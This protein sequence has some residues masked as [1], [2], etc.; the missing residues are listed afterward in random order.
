MQISIIVNIYI[1]NIIIV[2]NFNISSL[3]TKKIMEMEEHKKPKPKL[4][5][6]Q[7]AKSPSPLK[8][9]NSLPNLKR[10]DPSK[11]HILKSAFKRT[12]SLHKE[13]KEEVKVYT[14]SKRAKMKKRLSIKK[15]PLN[16]TGEM[17]YWLRDSLEYLNLFRETGNIKPPKTVTMKETY[18]NKTLFIDLDHTLISNVIDLG[19]GFNTFLAEQTEVLKISFVPRTSK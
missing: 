8:R 4:P 18:K 1:D 11:K 16:M 6:G 3:S 19:S 9:I 14:P 13:K 17:F 15:Y 5:M 12:D 10:E 2:Y 7:I